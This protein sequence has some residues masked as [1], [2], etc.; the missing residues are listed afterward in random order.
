MQDVVSAWWSTC[1]FFNCCTS[2][3]KWQVSQQMDRTWWSSS[4]AT[5]I[6]RFNTSWLFLIGAHEES[7]IRYSRGIWT[8]LNCQN[9]SS[10]W[11]DN[12]R[13]VARVHRSLFNR[14]RSCITVNGKHFEQLL[15]MIGNCSIAFQMHY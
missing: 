8:I 15:W 14:C 3:F 13:M 5:K 1:S 10:R 12:P 7:S 4:L 11:S 6:T 9:R 2:S